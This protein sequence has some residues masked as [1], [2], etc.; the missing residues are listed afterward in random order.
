MQRGRCC[1]VQLAVAAGLLVIV[2]DLLA[3]TSVQAQEVASRIT[4]VE[5]NLFS[6]VQ[7]QGEPGWKLGD[8][9][10]YYKV[11]GLSI[12]VIHHYKIEWARGY[13]W[14]DSAERRPV[15]VNTLF[16]AASISKSLSAVGDLRLAQQKR[17]SL[18]K[19]INTYLVRWKFPYDNIAGGQKIT[20]AELLSHMAG[21]SVHGFGG[22]GIKDSIPDLVAIL[23]GQPPAN[24]APVRSEFEPGLLMQYSGGGY[25]ITQLI[26][27]DVTHQPY[28][29]YMWQHVLKPLGMTRS[30]YMVLPPDSVGSELATAYRHDGRAIGCKYHLYPELAAAGLWATATDIARFVIA[31][32]LAYRGQSDKV[33]S[34]AMARRML[35]P[36]LNRSYGLGTVLAGHPADPY[37]QHTGLNEGFSAAYIGSVYGGDGVV[38]LLNSDNGGLIDE[39]ANS[40][41]VVYHWKNFSPHL[42]KK[43]LKMADTAMEK[44]AGTYRLDNS[45]DSV[46]ISFISGALYLED[47]RVRERQRVHFTSPDDFFLSEVR[48]AAY[49]FSKDVTGRVEC[50]WLG[51]GIRPGRERACRVKGPVTT[52]V[53]GPAEP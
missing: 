25:V 22:Y 41:A 9:M 40:V 2:I 4:Q 7:I 24:S 48:W 23:N 10:A 47:S 43:E 30:R 36:Y 17:I 26:V 19:D 35:T 27:E 37:F 51:N 13:G 39:I 3:I 12:A 31:M 5:Q 42:V 45:Q 34:P 50:L 44:Y 20:V 1:I 18:Y 46:V 52:N 33:L 21:L 32:Q 53:S 14:A 11:N 15:T 28:D 49:Q 38:I 16:Q 6:W 29:R 8:R